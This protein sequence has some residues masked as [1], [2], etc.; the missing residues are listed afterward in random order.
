[1]RRQRNRHLKWTHVATCINNLSVW[2][3]KSLN[4]TMLFT[5]RPKKKCV[6]QVTWNFKIGTMGKKIFLFYLKFLHG[7]DGETIWPN[8]QI[9][10]KSPKCLKHIFYF[11]L[12]LRLIASHEIKKILILLSED[13]FYLYSVDPDEMQ[14]HA[15]FHLNLPCLQK[16]LFRNLLNTKG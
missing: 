11:I 12:G 9:P 4:Y 13:L 10:C 14:Y 16:S 7:E 3:G 1:M 2:E 8:W 5:I 6:F 15:A